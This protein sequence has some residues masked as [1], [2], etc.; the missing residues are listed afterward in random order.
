MVLRR[1]QVYKLT[2][3]VGL[4]GVNHSDEL[5]MFC[6]DQRQKIDSFMNRISLT[7]S[8]RS[9]KYVSKVAVSTILHF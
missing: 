2:L 7:W 6:E 3:R 1:F 8:K 5:F 9:T 4:I